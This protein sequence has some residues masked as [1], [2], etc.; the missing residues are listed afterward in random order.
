MTTD[1]PV[2]LVDEETITYSLWRVTAKN[3]IRRF[4]PNLSLAH[5][6]EFASSYNEEAEPGVKYFAARETTICTVEFNPAETIDQRV[7]TT[8]SLQGDGLMR[9]LAQVE[10][11]L[12]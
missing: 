4:L 7:T 5:A 9:L 2:S 3:G 6:N 12:A 10:E 11:H 1:L 8:G